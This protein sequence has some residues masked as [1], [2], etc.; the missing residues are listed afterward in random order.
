MKG[1]VRQGILARLRLD[2]LTGLAVV[3][4]VGLTLMLIWWAVGILDRRTAPLLPAGLRDGHV[5]GLGV[6]VFV[7]LT[8]AVGAFVTGLMGR[9]LLGHG[10]GLVN[11]VPLVRSIYIAI[12]QLVDAVLTKGGKA[13]RQTALVEFPTRG[14][15]ALGFVSGRGAAEVEEKAGVGEMVA[16][17]MPN[18]PNPMTG[19]L[20]FVPK[21]DLRGLDMGF[22]E[23]IK[24]AMSAGVTGTKPE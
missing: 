12:K 9:A 7:A 23:G 13:F 10:E 21:S 22:E 6:V 17:V 20:L 2:F 18:T 14:R 5:A 8:I 24:L 3:L 15:W 1:R 16:V 11:R 19:I 4:P